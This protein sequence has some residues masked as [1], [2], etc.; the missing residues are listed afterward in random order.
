MS[1]NPIVDE[2]RRVRRE[3]WAKYDN[4]PAKY[5]AHLREYEKELR[6]QGYQFYD[7]RKDRTTD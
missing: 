1:D 7:P 3:L 5:F 2:V 4:D 6:A